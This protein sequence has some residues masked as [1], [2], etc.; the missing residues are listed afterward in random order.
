MKQILSAVTRILQNRFYLAV[1][2]VIAAIVF[3]L[4]FWIQ[5]KTVP[6]NDSR[7]QIAVFGWKDW[8]ILAIIAILN[9]IF[10]T[11][12]IYVFNIK[13]QFLA[14]PGLHLAS[15]PLF[16][17]SPVAVCALAPFLGFSEPIPLFS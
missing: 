13:R 10:I 6:G 17:V 7:L 9:S 14:G 16:S 5:V 2:I 12:E 1:C 3:S 4:L 15:W 8:A 11:I